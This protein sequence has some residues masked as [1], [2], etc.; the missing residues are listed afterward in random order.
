VG[1]AVDE[2]KEEIGAALLPIVEKLAAFLIETAVPNIQTFIG[3]LTGKGSVT[4]ATQDGTLGAFE[5]G[6]MVEKVIKTVY[7]FRGVL[8]ALGAVLLAYL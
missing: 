2:A 8:I 7:N 3:A 5:F 1:I 6:K 4:E